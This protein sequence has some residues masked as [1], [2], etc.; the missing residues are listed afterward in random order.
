MNMYRLG[1]YCFKKEAISFVKM[2]GKYTNFF[3]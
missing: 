3:K 2:F 1:Y